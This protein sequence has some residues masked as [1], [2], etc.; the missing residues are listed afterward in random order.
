MA[1]SGVSSATESEALYYNPAGLSW[2]E[3]DIRLVGV[4]ERGD[5]DSLESIAKI[6][7]STD[8]PEKDL[9]KALYSK[10]D[11]EKPLYAVTT[12]RAL[13][14]I[15][16]FIGVSSFAD[17]SLLNSNIENED[18]SLNREVEFKTDVG[19]IIGAG[20]RFKSLAFGVSYYRF[21]R[22]R[23]VSTPSDSQ[24]DA[25]VTAIENNTFS[26]TT[27]PFADFTRLEY[28]GAEGRNVGFQFRVHE[29]YA[30][31]FGISI[32]NQGGTTF[33]ADQGF[34]NDE[35]KKY[36]EEMLNQVDEFGIPIDVPEPIPEIINVGAS[37]S[38]FPHDSPFRLLVNVDGNDLEGDYIKE[39]YAASVEIGFEMPD[40]LALLASAPIPLYRDSDVHWHIGFAGLT[41]FAGIRPGA[42]MSTGARLKLHLGFEQRISIVKAELTAMALEPLEDNSRYISQAGTLFTA[43]LTF[44]VR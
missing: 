1:E 31:G 9:L 12:V 26:E 27:A 18:G 7:Q 23:V 22:A 6:A 40:E 41:A 29:D 38:L 36:E 14:V 8:D 43:G 21:G 39:K 3:V 5:A 10:L 11:S 34:T 16:P 35:L 2:F 20:V 42:Y 17:A 37:I 30:T 24:K 15:M 25:I 32:L 19:G 44:M 28:G 33:K 4:E 13:D